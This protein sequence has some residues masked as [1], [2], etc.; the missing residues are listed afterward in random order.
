MAWHPSTSV[1]V[2]PF[3]D[4]VLRSSDSVTDAYRDRQIGTTV[5]LYF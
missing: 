4:Q 3:V 5:K 1:E 2:S